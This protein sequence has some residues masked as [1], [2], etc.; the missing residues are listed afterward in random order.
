MLLH[1]N[2]LSISKRDA[3]CYDVYHK[4]NAL[5]PKPGEKKVGSHRVAALRSEYTHDEKGERIAIPGT[6]C[7]RWEHKYENDYKDGERPFANDI[8]KAIEALRFQTVH[9]AFAFYCS[10]VLI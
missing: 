10:Q 7:I 8:P 6:W 5:P 9:D 2:N 3:D 4:P 1:V